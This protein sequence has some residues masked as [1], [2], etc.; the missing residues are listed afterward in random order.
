LDS[1]SLDLHNLFL[2]ITL[3]VEGGEVSLEFTL[4]IEA[5]VVFLECCP[6]NT[7]ILF[8]DYILFFV[9]I[10]FHTELSA[11]AQKSLH[12]QLVI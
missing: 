2:S 12:F 11:V 10:T 7:H 6:E 8:L 4:L 9:V 3:F 1:S 5:G